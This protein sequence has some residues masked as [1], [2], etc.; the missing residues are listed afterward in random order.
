MKT[1]FSTL[2]ATALGLALTGAAAAQEFTFK[3]HHLLSA[4]APAHSKMLVPWAE[5]VE[6]NSNGRVKIEIFP[7]MS[8]GG[9][10]PEL[11]QQARDGVVDIVWT[12]NG[13][14]PGLF[15]RTEVFELPGVYKNDLKA[16]NIAMYDRDEL[17]HNSNAPINPDIGS[18]AKSKVVVP[19]SKKSVHLRIDADVLEFFKHEGKGHLTRMN[20]VLRRYMEAHISD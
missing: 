4:K 18:W 20:A 16:T 8:L 1:L 19:S 5:Q 17:V 10:P 13:Y 12:V 11:I 2:A 3:L 6:K 7:S 14:T 9:K 15:P